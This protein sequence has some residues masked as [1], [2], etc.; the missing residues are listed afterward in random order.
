MSERPVPRGTVVVGLGNPLMGDDGF[1]L[2][3]LARLAGTWTVDGDVEL[4][5]GGTWGLNL[6]PVIEGARRVLFL[7]AIDARAAPG[8]LLI[9]ENGELPRAFAF[10][11]SPHQVD[12]RD[13][14][15]LATWRGTLPADVVAVGVQP[16]RIALG[17]TLSAPLEAA[18]DGVV[19]TA[20]ARLREWGHACSRAPVP[21]TS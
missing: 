20:V 7:D 3:A 19:A 9:L 4:V 14:L 18:V 10:R 1:G 16:G 2:A 8:T 5:D 11:T 13:V 6:L 12:L 21:C 17:T 15:A